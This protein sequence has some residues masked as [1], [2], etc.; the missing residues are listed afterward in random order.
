MGLEQSVIHIY[1]VE[2]SVGILQVHVARPTYPSL[3]FTLFICIRN[4]MRAHVKYRHP[5]SVKGTRLFIQVTVASESLT[6]GWQAAWMK[7]M[8]GKQFDIEL[9]HG[10]KCQR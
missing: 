1:G 2:K 6:K 3:A 8:E 4:S 9:P 7:I 10:W 5:T